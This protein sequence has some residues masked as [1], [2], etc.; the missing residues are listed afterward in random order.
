MLNIPEATA[1]Q[2]GVKDSGVKDSNSI[3]CSFLTKKHET[4]QHESNTSHFFLI[5]EHFC[6]N[7]HSKS[8]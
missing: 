1:E 4:V 2:V 6:T 5:T 7:G 3:S 8:I